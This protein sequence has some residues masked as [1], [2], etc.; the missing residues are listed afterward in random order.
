MDI[1]LIFILLLLY[2][3][4]CLSELSFKI[5]ESE[6]SNLKG[7]FTI[8]SNYK[9][10]LFLSC[11]NGRLILNQKKDHFDI[12]EKPSNSYYI[13]CR[14]SMKILGIDKNDSDKLLLY[15]KFDKENKNLSIWELIFIKDNIYL[16]KNEFNKK[17]L[18]FNEKGMCVENLE[19]NT[20][21][22]KF[23]NNKY[24]FRILKL[25]EE[26]GTIN[27]SHI[28]MVE[29]EPIDLFM[30]YIDL[31]DKNLNR[32]GIQHIYKDFDNEELRYSLRSINE[33][34]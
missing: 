13:I 27:P 4:N 31:T 6:K 8:N 17:Y 12:I 21:I 34:D 30:K 33:L 7:T 9:Q 16:I 3:Y 19:K 22:N 1:L 26:I 24:M 10:N 18:N 25:Y 29:K 2:K 20:S 14:N 32:N 11:E 5:M 23:V 15:S 28:K